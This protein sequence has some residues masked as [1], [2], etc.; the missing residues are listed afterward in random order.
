MQEQN[1]R[2]SMQRDR[3]L[4]LHKCVCGCKFNIAPT[5]AQSNSQT[6]AI[7]D[8]SVDIK[9]RIAPRFLPKSVRRFGSRESRKQSRCVGLSS[10][11]FLQSQPCNIKIH[12]IVSF[13]TTVIG[14]HQVSVLVGHHKKS[15][16]MWDDIICLQSMID[17]NK[18]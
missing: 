17:S 4:T 13:N 3:I 12:L 5:T 10:T 9:F 18:I 15:D 2:K 7:T 14:R 8:V 6:I 11:I 16:S 1:I